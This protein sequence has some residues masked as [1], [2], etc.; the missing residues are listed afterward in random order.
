MK[1]RQPLFSNRRCQFLRQ[2]CRFIGIGVHEDPEEAKRLAYEDAVNK[3]NVI[4][5]K[6]LS[7]Y[8]WWKQS[9]NQV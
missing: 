8:H 6:K 7:L 3:A 1:P 5:I 9:K 2:R 4:S